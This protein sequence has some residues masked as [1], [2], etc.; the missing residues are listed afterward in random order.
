MWSL[1]PTARDGVGWRTGWS[2]RCS[3][4]GQRRTGWT[5]PRGCGFHRVVIGF[6]GVGI[7][8]HCVGVGPNDA[9]VGANNS[10]VGAHR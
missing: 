8:F 3:G 1:V 10:I 2:L 4:G 9:A 6:H 5:P 7:K